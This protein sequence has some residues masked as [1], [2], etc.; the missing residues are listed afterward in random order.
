[1]G[2]G[3]NGD[4]ANRQVK[5]TEA[6]ANLSRD[7]KELRD[8]LLSDSEV[9]PGAVIRLLADMHDLKRN[10]M[11]RLGFAMRSTGGV[12]VGAVIFLSSAA[13]AIGGALQVAH[14]LKL[15]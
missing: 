13:T 3:E 2:A 4:R 6:Y 10:P 11:V 8:A 7:I 5:A 12:A 15:I 1:M 9:A 14:W